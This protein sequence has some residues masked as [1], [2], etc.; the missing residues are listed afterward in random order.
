VRKAIFSLRSWQQAH[1]YLHSQSLQQSAPGWRQ[2]ADNNRITLGCMNARPVGN[3]AATLCQIIT[4]EHLDILTETWHESMVLITPPGYNC[5]DAEQPIPPDVR[6]QS[7]T[8]SS[9]R[10]R[11][12]WCQ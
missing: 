3:K 12:A 9:S 7:M 8:P 5:T 6:H 10:T 11:L 1:Q 4:D 2:V